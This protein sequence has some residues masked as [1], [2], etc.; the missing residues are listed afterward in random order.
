MSMRVSGVCGMISSKSAMKWRTLRYTHTFTLMLRGLVTHSSLALDIVD[1]F[2]DMKLI[3]NKRGNSL[4]DLR[5]LVKGAGL[6]SN[7]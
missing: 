7:C 2:F 3:I 6:V 5:L 4:E 1:F